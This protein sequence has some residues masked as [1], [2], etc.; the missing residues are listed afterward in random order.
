MHLT[1]VLGYYLECGCTN[2]TVL[3]MKISYEVRYKDRCNR[4][5]ILKVI[6]LGFL[7]I[8]NLPVFY[9]GRTERNIYIFN[10]TK[11]LITFDMLHILF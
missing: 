5:S 11:L 3:A 10:S 7:V 4:C 6:P 8:A 2:D 9:I 1:V